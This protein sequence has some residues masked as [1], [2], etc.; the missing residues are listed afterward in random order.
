MC[1]QKWFNEKVLG[2]RQR[3]NLAMLTGS[4]VHKGLE[5]HNLLRKDGGL[6][7]SADDVVECSVAELKARD[8]ITEIDESIGEATDTLVQAITGPVNHYLGATEVKVWRDGDPTKVGVEEEILWE[9]AGIPF[10]GYIDLNPD[11][12]PLIDFK[13]TGRRK[14]AH[15]V[16]FDGQLALYSMVKEKPA[17]FVQLLRGR[18]QSVY[19]EQEPT[20]QLQ[21]GVLGWLEGCVKGMEQARKTGVVGR[22]QPGDWLCKLGMCPFWDQCYGI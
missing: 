10:V 16:A 8:D 12:A 21:K 6:G 11:G 4:A 20:A 15:Q 19:A 1:P 2:Q 22:A 18:P 13:L 9:V 17:A 7:L 5:T 14:S 3:A